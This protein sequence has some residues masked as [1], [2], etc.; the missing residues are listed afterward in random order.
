MERSDTEEF[1]TI[2]ETYKIYPAQEWTSTLIFREVLLHVQVMYHIL[3]NIC[4]SQMF[5][6]TKEI[7]DE[8]YNMM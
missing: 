2:K 8:C 5:Q 6:Y 4:I 3:W 7:I 1:M